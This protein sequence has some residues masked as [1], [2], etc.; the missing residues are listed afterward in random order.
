MRTYALHG[1]GYAWIIDPNAKTLEVFK[2]ESAKWVFLGG[3]MSDDKVRAQPFEEVE[4]DL[5]NF[6]LEEPPEPGISAE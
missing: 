6:W 1:L 3:Y 4:L 2:L 5:A